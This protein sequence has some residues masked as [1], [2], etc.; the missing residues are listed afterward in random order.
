MREDL[1]ML[2]W[3]AG[4]TAICL[5][6]A[7]L[8]PAAGG[9]YRACSLDAVGLSPTGGFAKHAGARY[10][11]DSRGCF[12]IP[13][14]ELKPSRS[15]K[16]KGDERFA[17]QIVWVGTEARRGRFYRLYPE[18]VEYCAGA[19][20]GG[21]SGFTGPNGTRRLPSPHFASEGALGP[22]QLEVVLVFLAS[23]TPDALDHPPPEWN[24][25]REGMRQLL[26][27]T[28]D[29]L[30]ASILPRAYRH[31]LR[32]FDTATPISDV[33]LTDRF[34]DIWQSHGEFPNQTWTFHPPPGHLI[35]L[36]D[37]GPRTEVATDERGRV[38]GSAVSGNDLQTTR[39]NLFLG[40]VGASAGE[41]GVAVEPTDTDRAVKSFLDPDL[42]VSRPNPPLDQMCGRWTFRVP[43]GTRLIVNRTLVRF[44]RPPGE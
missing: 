41:V 33:T 16:L 27:R 42:D 44:P 11:L 28:E 2:R 4:A 1:S 17:D 29:D 10:P 43:V 24:D 6:L 34:P 8:A 7:G 5:L 32:Q 18:L 38:V 23:D 19:S 30:R 3:R 22:A 37:A 14:E 31:L 39:W 35:V 12:T 20:Q 9:D 36:K 26:A 40:L 25:A 15:I 13:E 21:L